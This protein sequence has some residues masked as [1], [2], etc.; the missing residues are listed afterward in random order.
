[1][2]NRNPSDS[3]MTSF[4]CEPYQILLPLPAI[5]TLDTIV[6]LMSS[7]PVG[8]SERQ[9][10]ALYCSPHTPLSSPIDFC[11]EKS[12]GFALRKQHETPL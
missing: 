6:S 10:G 4:L 3:G 2:E 1:M 7:K 12:V 5:G 11:I 8:S 9:C